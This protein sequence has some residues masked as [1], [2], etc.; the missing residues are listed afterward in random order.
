[1]LLAPEAEVDA[2]RQ[3]QFHKSL[4]LHG[5]RRVSTKKGSVEATT[6]KR[7]GIPLCRESAGADGSLAGGMRS[8]RPFGRAGTIGM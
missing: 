8:F 3:L 4:Q 6:E 1:M 5:L 2:V 7:H